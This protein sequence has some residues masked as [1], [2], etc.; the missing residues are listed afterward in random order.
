MDDG[1]FAARFGFDGDGLHGASAGT[2]AVARAQIDVAAVEAGGA[3][4]AV[5][6]TPALA[7]DL[8]LAVDAGEA[9]GFVPALAPV[10]R[11]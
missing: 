3:V 2:G 7:G 4:V 10:V 5:P 9:V 11:V 1:P 8:E 6:G